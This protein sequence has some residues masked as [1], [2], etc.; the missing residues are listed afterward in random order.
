MTPQPGK[1]TIAIHVLPNITKNKGNKA[2]KF[3]QLIGYNMRN[4]LLK[5]HIQNVLKKLFLDPYLKNQN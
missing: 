1:Q 2:M 5:N 3:S 4:I